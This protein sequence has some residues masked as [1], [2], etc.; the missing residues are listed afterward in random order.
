MIPDLE[1]GE[2]GQNEFYMSFNFLRK[3]T[4]N[5]VI[6]LKFVYIGLMTCIDCLPYN[7]NRSY[8]LRD[9]RYFQF[10]LKELF[11]GKVF[12]DFHP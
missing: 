11:L 9:L 5:H 10:D 6:L 8:T 12:M 7:L 2:Q 3:S 1:L 4:P